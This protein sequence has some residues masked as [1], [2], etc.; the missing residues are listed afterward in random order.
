M[1]ISQINS[2]YFSKLYSP[3]WAL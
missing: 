3:V 1:V 2:K